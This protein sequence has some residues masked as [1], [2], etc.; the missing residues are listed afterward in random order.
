M[1]NLF[2]GVVVAI[3]MIVSVG[4]LIYS[5][6]V[7]DANSDLTESTVTCT[8][9]WI[10]LVLSLAAIAVLVISI[11]KTETISKSAWM[12]LMLCVL[13]TSFSAFRFHS[14]FAGYKTTDDDYISNEWIRGN[15]LE[16]T[17][18]ILSGEEEAVVYIGRYDCKEC[19]EFENALTPILDRNGVEISGYYTDEDREQ[20]DREK[21][22]EFIKKYEIDSVPCVFWVKEGKINKKWNDP[23]NSLDEIEKA[24][25][26]E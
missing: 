2:A 8:A 4:C 14:E 22:D 13:A 19:I 7:L 24:I 5:G 21:Y 1:K 26:N 18:A 16:L 12:L 25:T 15:T 17:E 6:Y 10:A 20:A 3:C 23:I 9:G 11:V